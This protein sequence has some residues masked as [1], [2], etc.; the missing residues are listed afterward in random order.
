MSKVPYFK[1]IRYYQCSNRLT[2]LRR[3]ND[4]HWLLIL[5]LPSLWSTEKGVVSGMIRACFTP[6]VWLGVVTVWGSTDRRQA[7]WLRTEMLAHYFTFHTA[8][9]KPN[10]EGISLIGAEIVVSWVQFYVKLTRILPGSCLDQQVMLPSPVTST[11]FSVKDILKLEQQQ[12]YVFHQQATSPELDV[13]P[14]Q[15]LQCMHNALS[16][17]LDLLYCPDNA[18]FTASEQPK[19]GMNS[20]DDMLRG[21]N[22]P[23]EDEEDSGELSKLPN[24]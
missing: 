5:L 12:S 11:P 23:T 2:K 6:C 14:M 1:C 18:N 24:R 9:R 7:A 20:D 16:R 15:S 17:S 4:D 8:W 3:L 10:Q 22:S 21:C 13:P 19:C